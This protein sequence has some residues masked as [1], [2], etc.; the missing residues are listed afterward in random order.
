[1][2]GR[3][4]KEGLRGPFFSGLLLLPYGLWAMGMGYGPVGLTDSIA[5]AS[6]GGFSSDGLDRAR[7][8]LVLSIDAV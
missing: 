3:E 6:S 7:D 2:G 8:I 1:M 5:F 4:G